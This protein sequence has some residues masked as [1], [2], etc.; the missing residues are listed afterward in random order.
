MVHKLLP[1][2]LKR[3]KKK[4]H[5]Q[6][7]SSYPRCCKHSLFFFQRAF[8]RLYYLKSHPDAQRQFARIAAVKYSFQ[9]SAVGTNGLSFI[10]VL[11]LKNYFYLFIF[12]N[13]MA[14]VLLSNMASTLPAAKWQRAS[15]VLPRRSRTIEGARMCISAS[16][17]PPQLR[18]YYFEMV[19]I[20][21]CSK[22]CN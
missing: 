2:L 22:Y 11:F 16:P 13:L 15:W 5:A 18:S 1:S 10:A 4:E 14:S 3:K 7:H 20:C 21:T 8:N 19:H 17:A 6:F 12:Y 9:C